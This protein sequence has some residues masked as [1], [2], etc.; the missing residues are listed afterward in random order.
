[1]KKV[2]L[3][4]IIILLTISLSFIPQPAL[5]APKYKCTA[6]STATIGKGIRNKV[7]QLIEDRFTAG[8]SS[9]SHASCTNCSI[10]RISVSIST[11]KGTSPSQTIS[12]IQPPSGS[13]SIDSNSK[14][15]IA[16]GTKLATKV[17]CTIT[18]VPVKITLAYKVGTANKSSRVSGKVSLPGYYQ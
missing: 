18:D 6:I 14:V 2:Q 11:K 7:K 5:S 8:D 17:P 4:G 16:S 13:I 15:T 3:K 9:T 10:S 12:S 1:M